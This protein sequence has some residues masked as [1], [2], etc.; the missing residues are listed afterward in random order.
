MNNSLQVHEETA[1]SYFNRGNLFKQSGKLE[2]AAAAYRRCTELNPDFSWYHHNLGEVL[3]KLGQWDAAEKS[4]RSACELNQNSAWSWH[5]LG[6]VLEHQGNLDAAVTAY[7]KAVELYPDFYE[8]HNSL[9]KALCGQGQLDESI[10]C[11]RH[12][13]DLDS[14]SA[15][16]YQNLWEALARQG[17]VNEG[18]ECLQ[19]AIELNPGEPELYLKLAEALQGKN[20]LAE[21]VGYYRKAIQLQPDRH[22]PHYKLGTALSAQGKWEEAIASY[23]KAAELEPGSAIVHH[24][25][26]HTLSIVQRWDEAIE[27]YDKTLELVPDSAIVYQHLGDA[28][29]AQQKWEQAVGAYRKSVEFDPNSLEAQDHLG[30]ALYQLGRYDEA[31]SAYRRALEI[32][33]NSD[34]V[35]CHL[36]DA[37]AA[38]QRLDEAIV[39]YLCAIDIQPNLSEVHHKLGDVFRQ[40][41]TNS[42]LDQ[43][44]QCYSKTIELNSDDIQVYHKLLSLKPNEPELYFQ[45]GKALTQRNKEDEAIIFF[46]IVLQM[47]PEYVE[48]SKY[49]QYIL[50]KMAISDEDSNLEIV[51]INEAKIAKQIVLPYSP[52]PVVSVIIPVFNKIEYTLKCLRSLQGNISVNTEVEII[53]INDA[54]QDNT[55]FLLENVQ[56]IRLIN[57]TKN[58]GFIKSCNKAADYSHGK[59]LCFLNNDTEVRQGWLE[60][61]LKVMLSDED[62]GAVGS[63]LIY[64]NGVLQEA[65]G[66]IWS[67]AS[68]WNYGKMDNPDAPQY[69]YVRPVDYCSGASLLVRRQIFEDLN[70]F[71]KDFSPAYYE[72]T[73]LCF[74]IRNKLGLKVVYQPKSEVIHYEGITSGTSTASGAKRYQDLN[75]IKFK[76]K[77]QHTLENHFASGHTNN[78]LKGSRR[79]C[80]EKVILIVDD[81]LPCYDQESGGNRL[82]Q[83]IKIFKNYLN[84]HVIFAPDRA[85]KEEPYASEL[86]DMGIEVLYTCENYAHS[87]EEQIKE[88]LPLVNFAWICRPGLNQKYASMI[89]NYN[90]NIKII[91]DTVDLHYVRLKRLWELLPISQEKDEQARECQGTQELELSA[92]SFADLTVTVTEVEKTIL[93]DQSISKV[94]VIPNIH[95]QNEVVGKNFQERQDILF[96][97]GYKHLPNIDAVEWLCKSIMPKVWVHLPNVK[98]VL[99]GSH[100]PLAV[101]QLAI[102]NIDKVIVTGY[103]KD[104]SSFFLSHKVFV[105]PLRYGAGMKGKIGQSFEYQLPVVSTKVGAEGMGLIHDKSVLIADT[106]DDFASQIVRLY[107]NEQ[108]WD[109]LSKNSQQALTPYTPE[110]VQVLLAKVMEKLS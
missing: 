91:Y 27:S 86:Q 45:L 13:I 87:I 28:L 73:D 81:S 74:T 70:G 10:S 4:Y 18:I 35:H 30:F 6:E 36:G 79:L 72:D 49:L 21:A 75:A 65:G 19:R 50:D 83:L 39:N 53:V 32:S 8:F 104:V 25:L 48:A 102:D 42:D 20:E 94:A 64:P 85:I 43:A 61:L 90:A 89:R 108:L 58:I 3:T 31:I 38:L 46:Q 17:R 106:A 98:V 2:E 34:V 107:T 105:A 82:Y 84:Y 56:G 11:L 15:L 37:M 33:P 66:V 22:W 80:G 92:A 101:Q 12:A 55:Q 77:W 109:K 59:Y 63:K 23:S 47:K 67:D 40:R 99:L 68:G 69:N 95:Q 76:N 44:Y 29:A 93:L 5:N 60:S 110:Y 14:E 7:R 78:P 96:I 24:Y 57:N 1:S 71:E 52:T 103:V 26:G 100:P 88:R 51:P 41:G 97:G 54:S 9:G 62:V 16:P